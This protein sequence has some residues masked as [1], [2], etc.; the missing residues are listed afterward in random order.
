MELADGSLY[1]GDFNKG[2]IEGQGVYKWNNGKQYNGNWLT[3]KMNGFGKLTWPDGVEYVGMFENDK[4]NGQGQYRW[5]DGKTYIG[6]WIA[7]KQHGEGKLINGVKIKFGTWNM[8]NRQ[9]PWIKEIEESVNLNS[10][11]E[12]NLGGSLLSGYPGTFSKQKSL[13]SR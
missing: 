9:G 5:N 7:G 13:I 2:M 3:S 10:E 1:K 11:M 6:G 8:G 4:F 12:S